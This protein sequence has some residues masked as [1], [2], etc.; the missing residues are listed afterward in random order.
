MSFIEK[1]MDV[2]LVSMDDICNMAAVESL[3]PEALSI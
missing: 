3:C 2:P 1:S